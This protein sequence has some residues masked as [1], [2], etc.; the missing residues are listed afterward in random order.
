MKT[1]DLSKLGSMERAEAIAILTAWQNHGLPKDF[2]DSEV[3][4]EFNQSNGMVYLTN[5][6]SEMCMV[7]D[8]K[9]F[10]YY[11]S[12]YGEHQGSFED[13]ISEYN[14]MDEYDQAW[15]RSVA[16]RLNRITELA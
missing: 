9:L 10:E 3:Q 4:I 8:G 2:A 11:I 15:F 14:H 5:R 13:L 6:F 16:G 7:S 1:Q 12:P